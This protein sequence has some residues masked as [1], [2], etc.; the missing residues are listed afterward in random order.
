MGKQSIPW[1]VG[2]TGLLYFGMLGYWQYD[3]FEI[4]LGLSKCT[5]PGGCQNAVDGAIFGFVFGIVYVAFMIWC[6]Q[7]FVCRGC[8]TRFAQFPINLSHSVVHQQKR[9]GVSVVSGESQAR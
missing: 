1:A 9:T 6:S 5:I 7:L 2:L 3:A 8:H 4:A